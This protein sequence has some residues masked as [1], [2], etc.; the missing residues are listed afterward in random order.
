MSAPPYMKLYIADYHV[1]TTELDVVGHGAY[2]LLLMAMWRAGGKLPRDEAKL[3]R[4]AKCTP[5]QW[6]SVRDDVMAHFK[7]SG[8]AIRH[9]RVAKEMAKYQA[10]VDGAGAAGKASASKR[11]NKHKQVGSTDVERTDQRLTN[12]PEPEP[13]PEPEPKP[14]EEKVRT[15]FP[16][17]V[18]Q[19]AAAESDQAARPKGTRLAKNWKA[20]AEQIGF[21]V[22]EGF[23]PEQVN[24]IEQDFRDFWTAKSSADA[25]KLDWSATWRRWVRNTDR[26]KLQT[27]SAGKRVGFV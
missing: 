24:R 16:E 15:L 11:A 17:P 10:V 6:A 19:A 3:S 18:A 4:L 14:E 26:R 12:Q 7:V 22:L 13:E 20:D 8:G 21:A 5:D 25:A 9:T 27:V 2:L 23:S 1:E